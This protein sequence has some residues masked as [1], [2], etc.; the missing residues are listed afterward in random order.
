MLK[1]FERILYK[2]VNDSMTLFTKFSIKF[3]NKI[4]IFL[5]KERKFW[6]THLGKVGQIVIILTNP[7]NAFGTLNH[8]LSLANWEVYCFSATSLGVINSK[9]L[10]FSSR[11]LRIIFLPKMLLDIFFSSSFLSVTNNKLCNWAY[12]ELMFHAPLILWLGEA[13]SWSR[14]Y[15]CL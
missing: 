10:N 2:Q 14:F 11:I 13:K 1:V 15:T 5:L 12:D 9:G 6:K 4:M 8:C 7:S 3:F